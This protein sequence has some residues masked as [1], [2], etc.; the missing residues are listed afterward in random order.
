MIAE[1]RGIVI[2]LRETGEPI[3]LNVSQPVFRQLVIYLL[4]AFIGAAAAESAI[5]IEL[6]T[7]DDEPAI[8][9]GAIELPAGARDLCLRL[10]A[11][12]TARA[13]LE[14]LNAGLTSCDRPPRI[15]L[16]FR[17]AIQRILIVDDNPDTVNLFQRY[18]A[19]LPYQL[20]PAQDEG[21][22][23]R[24]ARGTPLLCIIL[25]VMLPGKD[26]WQILQSCKNH[27]DTAET[28]V[29]I[30]S[31]LEMEDLALSLGADGYLKKPPSREA[32]LATLRQWAG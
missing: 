29:L 12:E 25:D 18:L 17:Q 20:L 13:L 9:F 24:I 4:N 19:N 5:E 28:P 8:H 1:D 22:A 14:S 2:R 15:T 27:P 11:D 16:A 23:L 10:G 7:L 26:G 3:R 21:E 31:V 32:L 6:A 30:C